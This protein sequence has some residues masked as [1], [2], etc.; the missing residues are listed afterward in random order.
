MNIYQMYHKNNCTLD[1]YVVRDS[2]KTI[3]AKI[4]NIENVIIGKKIIGK[5]P[6]YNN[7]KVLAEFYK[8]PDN[9]VN[10][11]WRFCTQ[12]NLIETNFLSCPGTYAYSQI[13]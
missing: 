10:E 3:I 11:S 5:Y 8:V 1:F 6:Y 13:N 2:W 9:E 12:N 7:P 4:I